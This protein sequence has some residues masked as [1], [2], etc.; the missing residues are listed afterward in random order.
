MLIDVDNFF[1]AQV[2]LEIYA[3]NASFKISKMCIFVSHCSLWTCL[4]VKCLPIPSKDRVPKVLK[5][6]L[7]L[8]NIL[9]S[10]KSTWK[11]IWFLDPNL[12]AKSVF[13]KEEKGRKCLATLGSLGLFCLNVKRFLVEDKLHSM[14]SL[15]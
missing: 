8:S 11:V 6:K 4:R 13:A 1:V 9:Y 2:V 15:L 10:F 7:P 14:K 3:K 5:I 12:F